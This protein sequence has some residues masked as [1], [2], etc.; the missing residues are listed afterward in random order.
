M[1]MV[2]ILLMVK[3]GY[4]FTRKFADNMLYVR[5]KGNELYSHSAEIR[6]VSEDAS[7]P[8]RTVGVRIVRPTAKYTNNQIVVSVPNVRKPVPLFILMRALGLRS[9]KEIIHYCL[10]DMD[11]YSHYIDL[12]I[13]SIHDRKPFTQ[14]LCLKY[15]A[16]LTKG[17]T[18]P[19]VMDI[20]MNYL[21]HVGEL[22]FQ[23]KAYFVGHMVRE[24][25]MVFTNEKKPTDRDN[26][27]FKRI[28]TSGKLIYDLFK[29]YYSRQQRQI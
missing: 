25:L 23:E 27:K 6:S 9:D 7:K 5:G 26:F 22:N 20:L 28:E 16:S 4:N 14:E 3:K 21:P 11:K 15:I 17:K 29:E 12:F 1:I 2:V 24:L 8:V 10:F 18:I 19:T 13:P